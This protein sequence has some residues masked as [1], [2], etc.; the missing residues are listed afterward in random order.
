MKLPAVPGALRGGFI[1]GRSDGR[2]G[3]PDGLLRIVVEQSRVQRL[4]AS[5]RF[6]DL[7]VEVVSRKTLPKPYLAGLTP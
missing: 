1:G 4:S 5:T 2:F 7:H 6:L 3:R